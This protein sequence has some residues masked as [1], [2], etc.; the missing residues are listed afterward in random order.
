VK[1]LWS[2]I[3]LT[4]VTPRLNF[5]SGSVPA[6]LLENGRELLTESCEDAEVTNLCTTT[7]W[8]S[9]LEL[10]CDMS[11]AL[12]DI[13]D[14]TVQ[15]FNVFTESMTI[16][17]E[18]IA[19][20]P[21]NETI[22]LRMPNLS[23]SGQFGTGP[24]TLN[25]I[26]DS[27]GLVMSGGGSSELNFCSLLM[28]TPSLISCELRP[29]VELELEKLTSHLGQ[30]IVV[31]NDQQTTV[32]A[33]LAFPRLRVD[34]VSP[35]IVDDVCFHNLTIKGA[36]F[37]TP[38]HGLPTVTLGQ[39][40]C[41]VW[42]R[43][44]ETIKCILGT[45][46]EDDVH[47]GD[48]VE[49]HSLTVRM[50]SFSDEIELVLARATCPA[51]YRRDSR[52]TRDC[53]ICETMSYTAA[54]HARRMC[55][56]CTTA[57]E[58]AVSCPVCPARTADIAGRCE[59]IQ[60]YV[61]AQ[62]GP[63]GAVVCVQLPARAQKV[64]GV[65]GSAPG[66][67]MHGKTG[68]E[69]DQDSPTFHSLFKPCAYPDTCTGMNECAS[70]YKGVGCELCTSNYRWDV[71]MGCVERGVTPFSVFAILAL[72]ALSI[73]MPIA[74]RPDPKVDSEL[75][76]LG[77]CF[78]LHGDDRQIFPTNAI[79]VV[80]HHIFHVAQSLVMLSR[81]ELH[82]RRWPESDAVPR[83][84]GLDWEV[85]LGLDREKSF[86]GPV[87]WVLATLVFGTIAAINGYTTHFGT[88]RAVGLALR[89]SAPYWVVTAFAEPDVEWLDRVSYP[90]LALGVVAFI[91]SCTSWVRTFFSCFTLALDDG[92]HAIQF[93]QIHDTGGV[94]AWGAFMIGRRV[95]F[96]V[97]SAFEYGLIAPCSVQIF[98]LSLMHSAPYCYSHC[99][100]RGTATISEI[101]VALAYAFAIAGHRGF[102][103]GILLSAMIIIAGIVAFKGYDCFGYNQSRA[104][105]K[106]DARDDAE[107]V[108]VLHPQ[109]DA[110]PIHHPGH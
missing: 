87:A 68:D 69:I 25:F 42:Y 40:P 12:G 91:L 14:V 108:E 107:N 47:T 82:G 61:E 46:V 10:S 38:A 110:P 20:E 34:S 109:H 22:D 48:L 104:L 56:Y 9:T 105:Q 85:V 30:L 39:T 75:C 66:S 43:D 18:Q 16:A 98:T 88:G 28:W 1:E 67:W 2:R 52:D 97:L 19:L 106:Y 35:S 80:L 3:P 13:V 74:Y 71:S 29:Y 95:I 84:L 24:L 102:G 65:V 89:H 6:S 21:L 37:G 72:I 60:Q 86:W 41:S 53:V 100:L 63:Y 59:C 62:S 45:R 70:G 44:A 51:G 93:D 49:R 15:V 78:K 81:F 57:A 103:L 11:T 64:A 7:H 83:A 76:S 5:T 58:G 32:S 92:L 90:S 31:Q 8:H 54:P 26:P 36:N 4:E 96:A 50:A 23:F 79:P 27:S 73:Y 55:D 94:R 77:A 33:E 17:V 101:A 99:V